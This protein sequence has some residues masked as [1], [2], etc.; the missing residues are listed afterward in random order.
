MTKLQDIA[1]TKVFGLIL[2]MCNL[3]IIEIQNLFS[4]LSMCISYF[5]YFLSKRLKRN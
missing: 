3:G 1:N 4:T 2:T 5:S